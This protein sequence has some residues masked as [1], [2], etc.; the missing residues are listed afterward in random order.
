MATA[1]DIQRV[2]RIP[3]MVRYLAT[4]RQINAKLPR[5]VEFTDEEWSKYS[6]EYVAATQNLETEIANIA[7]AM[8]AILQ[9]TRVAVNK[10]YQDG[11]I[12]EADLVDLRRQGLAGL[13]E[14]TLITV[15]LAVLIAAVLTAGAVVAF[16]KW[17]AAAARAQAAATIATA[18]AG[19]ISSGQS[20][21]DV[22]QLKDILDVGGNK[23]GPLDRFGQA[24]GTGIGLA[25]LLAVALFAFNRKW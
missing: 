10:L 5:P 6:F 16:E 11:N 24:A 19:R 13:G 21:P 1:T 25:A 8:S 4:L 7:T 22:S 20:V 2:Q 18:I 23:P 17:E 9:E 12:G 14:L 15:G 3:A